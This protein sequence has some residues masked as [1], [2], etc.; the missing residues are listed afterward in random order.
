MTTFNL[1]KQHMSQKD[2]VQ[3]LTGI[4]AYILSGDSPSSADP[5]ITALWTN[6]LN[7]E[8]E[9]EEVTKP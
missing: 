8:V 4:T 3:F 7:A 5:E 1:I 2:L 6:I 9:L